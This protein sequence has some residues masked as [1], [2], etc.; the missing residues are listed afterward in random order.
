MDSSCPSGAGSSTHHRRGGGQDH[1]KSLEENWQQLARPEL[2]RFCT[3]LFWHNTVMMVLEVGARR[4]PRESKC[5]RWKK[6]S[7]SAAM[8]EPGVWLARRRTDTL[9]PKQ[10]GWVSGLIGLSLLSRCNVKMSQ[11]FLNVSAFG[12]PFYTHTLGM[13]LSLKDRA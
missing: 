12:R 1:P 7:R 6:L 4:L 10:T 3:W 5:A 8:K 11:V 9:K 2:R 13:G